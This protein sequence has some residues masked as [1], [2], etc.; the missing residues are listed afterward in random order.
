MR[1]RANF[2]EQITTLVIQFDSRSRLIRH[3][4]Q[5][6]VPEDRVILNRQP[7]AKSFRQISDG[8]RPTVSKVGG[9][10]TSTTVRA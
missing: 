3:G 8:H 9:Q 5:Y 6:R 7:L 4:G 10:S 1:A 2:S